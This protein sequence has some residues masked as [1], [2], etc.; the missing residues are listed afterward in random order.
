M[1]R[2]SS[3]IDLEINSLISALPSGLLSLEDMNTLHVL[4]DR[5]DK[6]IAHEILTWKLKRRTKWVELG[7]ANT[8]YFHTLASPRRKFNSI[9]ALKNEEDAWVENDDQLKE[10]GVKQFSEIFK[11]DNQTN[12]VDQLKVIQLFPSFISRDE[13]DFFYPEISVG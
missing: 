3:A 1:K 7:D 12:I 9:W 2:E 10:L 13:A 11:D 6:F 4:E 8:K 5:K